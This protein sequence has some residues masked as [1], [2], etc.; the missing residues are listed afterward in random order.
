VLEYNLLFKL[1]VAGVKCCHVVV[2]LHWYRW[3]DTCSQGWV[4]KQSQLSTRDPVFP[5]SVE[6]GTN[7]LI[8]QS[9]VPDSQYTAAGLST[10]SHW[11]KLV[12]QPDIQTAGWNSWLDSFPRKIW[13]FSVEILYVCQYTH[14]LY[15][16]QAADRLGGQ[17]VSV[18]GVIEW[19]CCCRP[20]QC[21]NIEMRFQQRHQWILSP[22]SCIQIPIFCCLQ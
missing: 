22:Y 14:L 8:S 17:L 15:C 20:P 3:N 5:K 10:S 13:H 18:G 19:S 9:W 21:Y 2:L 16:T 7:F 6:P 1:A 12:L 4:R 11:M